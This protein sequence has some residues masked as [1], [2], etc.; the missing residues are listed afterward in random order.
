MY[1]TL[2]NLKLLKNHL[3]ISLNSKMFNSVESKMMLEVHHLAI[4]SLAFILNEN[5]HS[6]V[7]PNSSS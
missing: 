5:H 7:F 4:T 1:F 3:I 2:L 6:S